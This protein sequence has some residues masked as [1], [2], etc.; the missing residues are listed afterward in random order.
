MRGDVRLL[1]QMCGCIMNF[2]TCSPFSELTEPAANLTE[3]AP[4]PRRAIG[5]ARPRVP[6][7][8]ARCRVR[9]GR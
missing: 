1:N 7:L 8:A 6:Q 3:P 5:I 4:W 2:Y 9:V